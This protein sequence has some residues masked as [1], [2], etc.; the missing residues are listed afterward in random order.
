LIE[1]MEHKHQHLTPAEMQNKLFLNAKFSGV[2]VPD[3]IFKIALK[4]P[5][6]QKTQLNKKIP[7][8]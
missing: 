5:P 2:S 4:Q 8:Q 7:N 3:K 1:E 6:P